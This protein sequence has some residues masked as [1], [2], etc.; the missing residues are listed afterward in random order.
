M[1]T[2]LPHA[3]CHLF[4]LLYN[5]FATLHYTTPATESALTLVVPISSQ[6]E[7]LRPCV[8]VVSL[9]VAR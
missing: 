1:C 6:A 2:R 3:T 7:W 9:L 8:L 5:L 4:T